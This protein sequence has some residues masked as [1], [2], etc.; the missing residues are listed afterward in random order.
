M[1]RVFVG[2][3]LDQI[4][5]ETGALAALQQ[6]ALAAAGGDPAQAQL[7]ELIKPIPGIVD[8][9]PQAPFHKLFSVLQRTVPRAPMQPAVPCE[10]V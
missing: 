5:I 1:Q 7:P 9:K 10:V 6:L 3:C 8:A 2:R 4:P